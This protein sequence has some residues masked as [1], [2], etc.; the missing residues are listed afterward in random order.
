MAGQQ[1]T[2]EIYKTLESEIISLKILPGDVLSENQLCKRFG[3]SRT[4]IRSVLQRL[5]QSGFVQIIPYRGTIVTPIDLDK[6][7]QMIYQRVAVES[8]VLRDFTRS[9]SPI[10]VE[11]VRHAL[12]QLEEEALKRED[13]S[14]FDINRFLQTDLAMHELWFRF[15]GKT[16][17][18]QNLLLPQSDYARLMRLDIVG[19]RN[20][21]DVLQE[22]REFMRI[23]DEKDIDAIEPIVTRHLYGGVR[24]TS[25]QIFSDEYSRFF[26][27]PDENK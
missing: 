11:Q 21:P 22:H 16:F 12:R 18:W 10:E 19:G 13:L 15:T 2:D 4:P 26:R 7:N 27:Q 1:G 20:V 8:M 14:S 24:R 6:A 25:E 23:I 5:E 9:A 17:L 3:V